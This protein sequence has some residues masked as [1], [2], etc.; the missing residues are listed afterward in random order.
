MRVRGFTLY[1]ILIVF[2][3]SLVGIARKES[4]IQQKLQERQERYDKLFE[5]LS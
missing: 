5:E 4:P 3:L 2:L 1:L